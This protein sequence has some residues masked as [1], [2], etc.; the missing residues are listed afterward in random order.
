MHK[1]PVW[2]ALLG[3]IFTIVLWF[4]IV[5]FYHLY[6]YYSLK[7]TAKTTDVSWFVEEISSED[8]RVGATYSFRVNDVDY[9]GETIFTD[10]RF[11]NP[12]SADDELK[13]KSTDETVVFY[14]PRNIE[15]SSLEKTFPLKDSAT[16]TVLFL[17]FLYLFGLGIYTSKKSIM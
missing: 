10:R 7:E 1:N 12:S 4:S 13:N 14:N 3:L 16:A 11:R 9:T 6:T 5:A 2:L 15:H 17:L 8:F